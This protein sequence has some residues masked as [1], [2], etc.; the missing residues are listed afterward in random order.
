LPNSRRRAFDADTYHPQPRAFGIRPRFSETRFESTSDPPVRAV[1]KW[2]NPEKS[3]WPRQT[4]RWVR[5]RLSPWHRRGKHAD[6]NGWYLH[7][8]RVSRDFSPGLRGY[9]VSDW[10]D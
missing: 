4:V 10:Y 9:Q 1:V 8:A 5:R 6:L 7:E 2:F 3:I